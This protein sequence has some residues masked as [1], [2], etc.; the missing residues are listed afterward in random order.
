VLIKT[1]LIF[2]AFWQ[3]PNNSIMYRTFLM[4]L[5]SQIYLVSLILILGADAGIVKAPSP[6]GASPIPARADPVEDAASPEL[7]DSTFTEAPSDGE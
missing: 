3:G 6:K 7:D 1:L 2:K 4:R 5:S